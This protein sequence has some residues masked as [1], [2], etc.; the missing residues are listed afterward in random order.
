MGCDKVLS[1]CSSQCVQVNLGTCEGGILG[2]GSSVKNFATRAIGADDHQ[3]VFEKSPILK[4]ACP[5][6]L[7][8]QLPEHDWGIVSRRRG[9]ITDHCSIRQL[10]QQLVIA[11]FAQDSSRKSIDLR[12]EKPLSFI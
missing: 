3:L 1:D 9:S 4:I 6:I 2:V 7:Q 10:G 12:Q 8:K 11:S 5:T